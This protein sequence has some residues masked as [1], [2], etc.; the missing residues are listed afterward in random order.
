MVRIGSGGGAGEFSIG[1]GDEQPLIRLAKNSSK[2]GKL[3]TSQLK[4][5]TELSLNGHVTA[6]FKAPDYLQAMKRRCK[7]G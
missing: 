1:S 3:A 4:G 6:N 7:E 5:K 2:V